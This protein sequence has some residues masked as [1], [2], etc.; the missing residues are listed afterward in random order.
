[1]YYIKLLIISHFHWKSRNSEQK[2]NLF[3]YKILWCA[4]RFFFYDDDDGVVVVVGGFLVWA[5]FCYWYVSQRFLISGQKTK[6]S[7]IM[8]SLNN[9]KQNALYE[10]E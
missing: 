2:K 7:Q 8:E 10:Y 1:M 9:V 6:E 4:V 3:C 5:G